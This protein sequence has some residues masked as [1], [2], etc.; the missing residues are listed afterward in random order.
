MNEMQCDTS[1]PVKRSAEEASADSPGA[2][3]AKL[4]GEIIKSKAKKL[5]A[6]S[7]AELLRFLAEEPLGQEVDLLLLWK[8]NEGRFEVDLLLLWKINEGRFTEIAMLAKKFLAVLGT[9]VPAE[10][11]FFTAGLVASSLRSRLTATNVDALVSNNRNLLWQEAVTEGATLT[12]KPEVTVDCDDVKPTSAAAVLE[13]E[14]SYD[15]DE[16]LG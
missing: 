10:C 12:V 9:S 4:I 14:K 3:R 2:K 7:R 11:V 1:A 6:G 8:I 15:E 5:E 13:E 16:L